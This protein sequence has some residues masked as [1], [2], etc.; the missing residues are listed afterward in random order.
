MN[1]ISTNNIWGSQVNYKDFEGGESVSGGEREGE[2]E[3]EREGERKR[4]ITSFA[5]PTRSNSEYF[6]LQFLSPQ[7]TWLDTDET[8][9]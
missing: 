5:P 6:S 9:N 7:H 1:I 3:R 2:K 4:E 8:T